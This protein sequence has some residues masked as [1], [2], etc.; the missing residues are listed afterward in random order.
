MGALK[1][2]K[3]DTQRTFSL[4]K[5]SKDMKVPGLQNGRTKM[6]NWTSHHTQRWKRDPK[7]TMLITIPSKT[8]LSGRNKKEMDRTMTLS[9]PRDKIQHTKNPRLILRTISKIPTHHKKPRPNNIKGR[10]NINRTIKKTKNSRS[11][12]KRHPSGPN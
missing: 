12:C 11:I 9:T 7:P 3:F 4:R 10:I 8:L 6:F 2:S 1:I 5:S